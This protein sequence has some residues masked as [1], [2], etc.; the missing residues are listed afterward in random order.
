[1]H[2]FDVKTIKNFELRRKTFKTTQNYKS[3]QITT[4]C[5]DLTSKRSKILSY[6]AK[7]SKQRKTTKV[8]KIQLLASIRRR[9]DKKCRVKSPNIQNNAKLQKW[10]YYDEFPSIWRQNDKNVELRRKTFKTTLN[11]KSNQITMTCIDLM[12][13][14]S[15]QRKTTNTIKLLWIASI[16]RHNDQK[17][18]VTSQCIQNNAKLQKWSYNDEFASISCQNDQNNSKLQKRSN[19]NE[20]HRFDVIT[21]KML[22]Y[23]AMHS[24]QHKTTKVIKLQWLASI[25]CQ[26]HQNNEKLQTRSNYNDLHRFDVKTIKTIKTTQNYKCDQITMNLHRFDVNTIKNVEYVAKHSKQH[27]TTKVIK[28]RQFASIWRQNDQK[29][30]VTSQNIPNNAKLQKWSY[31]DEFAS[32]SCQND[33]NNSKLQKRSNYN[34]FHR[35]DVIT[36]KMLSY[37]A[38][39]SKQHKT[40]KVIKLQWLASI[41]CQNIL[42]Y[43]SDQNTKTCIDFMSNRSKQ[44]KT[45]KAIKLQ[46]IAT[47]WRH[48]DQ[49][50]WIR[51]QNNQNNAKLQKWSY[52]DEFASISCLNDQN[53]SKLQKRSNYNELHRFDVITIKNVVLR[54][55]AFKTTQNYKS[56]Q[57]TMTCIYLM[58]KHWKQPKTKIV[59]ILRWICIYLM[60]NRSKMLSYVSM[61]SKQ[62]KT[63]KVIKLQWLASIWCQ[64]ILN[65]KS[66]QNTKTCIDFMSNRSKQLKTT[67]TIKLQWIASIWRHNDKKC[68]VTS[69]CI[70]NNAKLQKWSY[71]DEFASIS[72]QNDQN[73]S[74]LQK[75]IKLQWIAS[76]WRHNDKNVELRRNAFKT[77]QNYKS[78]QITMTCIYLMSKHWKQPK[79]K[80]V[81]ILRWICIYLMSN[82]SKML[83]YVSM[84]SKQHKTTKVIKLQWLASIGRQNDQKCWATSQN[85]QNN[86]KLPK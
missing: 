62:H 49:K 11:Y 17:C 63:T 43:K 12:S 16:W 64:N 39:H 78:N 5:I 6:V 42:N 7:H 1:M 18:W 55:N 13:K 71:N 24:K 26:K 66:D 54:R 22:S 36:I 67:K 60:S 50:C 28:L 68:W 46:C 35:F 59:I 20:L 34:E 81:I 9:K 19:Y 38:M 4:I 86:A 82:R 80:I 72:C 74:K 44:L 14:T 65:Y 23:V 70:Q 47:I 79:T 48:N 10:S 3:N 21:I 53:N 25:W 84:H 33:Q 83:S 32:I 57:I 73:N 27:K 40:T 85:M 8:I 51:S 2:R 75:T 45:T 77:T 15:K 56:N 61:H 29:S 30:W 37:V 41:W 31:N 69:Q 76:I 58:S 52:N